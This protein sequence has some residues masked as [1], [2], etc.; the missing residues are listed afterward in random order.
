MKGDGIMKLKKLLALVLSVAMLAL[1]LSGCGGET[2]ED[3]GSADSSGGGDASEIK[4]GLLLPGS[5]NDGGWSQMAADAFEAAANEYGCTA[6]YT[7]SV[8]ATDMETIMRGYADNGY[9]IIVSHGAEFLDA[10][11][12]V[13]KD[14]PDIQ[15]I[16]T[17]SMNGMDPNLAGIDFGSAELG[18]I[19]GLI[20]GMATESN[21][22]GLVCAMEGDTTVLCN[23]CVE[24]AAKKINPDIEVTVVYTG[25]FDDQLK[26]KQATA[27]LI[28][29][30]CDVI[31]MNCD[32]A[33][34]GAVQQCDEAG[35]VCVPYATPMD[36]QGSTIICQVIQDAQLGIQVAVEKA[37]E[38]TLGSGALA[39][40][41]AENVVTLDDFQGPYADVLTDD[42]VNQIKEIFDKV[43][44]GE[45]VKEV[46]DSTF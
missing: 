4:M 45:D 33:A 36:G 22:I 29:N 37:I 13:A 43:Y 24:Y 32:A 39:M 40:G 23:E 1:C 26:A 30:G 11:K 3:G 35:V 2:K 42:E 44:N 14:Y 16:N 18:Y 31:A 9:S 21:K 12:Q 25:S 15:F 46:I 19:T 41:I 7:E 10:S 28:N 38:G 17:S 5:A 34:I 6:D 8:A 27:E 20:A